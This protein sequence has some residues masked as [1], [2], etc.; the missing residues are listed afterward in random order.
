MT[1][2]ASNPASLAAWMATAARLREVAGGVVD[3]DGASLAELVVPEAAGADDDRR[4]PGFFRRLDV[5]AARPVVGDA[6]G[7]QLVQEDVHVA[8]LTRTGQHE[9]VTMFLDGYE[10]VTGTERRARYQARA[11]WWLESMSV[12]SMS[13]TAMVE[14]VT[15]HRYPPSPCPSAQSQ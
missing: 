2:F 7:V 14:S 12:P 8:L 15:A 3:G 1:R 10:Q 4:H 11:C 9:P 13:R 5:G 6:A